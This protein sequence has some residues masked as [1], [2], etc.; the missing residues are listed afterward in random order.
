MWNLK[1]KDTNELISL[2]TSKTNLQ[3]TKVE[4]AGGG[5]GSGIG[6]C[7]LLY[8]ERMVDWDLHSEL[9]PVFSG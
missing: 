2:Q 3:V 1:K 8:V 5:W 6:T 7:T 9:Y 4:M